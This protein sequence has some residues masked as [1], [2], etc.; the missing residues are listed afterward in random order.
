MLQLY[1]F[2]FDRIGAI[3][4][5][6]STGSWSVTGR[7]LTYSM[8]ELATTTSFPESAFP[9]SAFPTSPFPSALSYFHSL[10]SEQKTHLW[11]QRNLCG[12]PVEAR[13]RYISRHLFAQSVDKYCTNDRGP[14]KFFCDDFRPQNILVDPT[15][16]RITAV[17]D[18]EFSNAMPSQYASEPPW[19]LLLVG[20]DS[21]LLRG[22]TIAG[23]IEAYEPR[24][25]QFLGAMERAEKARD[26]GENG[27]GET[28]LS[29]LMRESWA[30]KR[31]WFNYA[32]RKPFD[33]EVLFDTQLR[34]DGAGIEMLDGEARKGLEPFV[35]MKMAQLKAY[36]NE[37]AKRLLYDYRLVV[38]LNASPS[39][40]HRI[41]Q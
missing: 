37:C 4:N 7:P 26:R 32:A 22:K 20:P 17:L 30:T 12:S 39:D 35:A 28:P 6:P 40:L 10:T 34:G 38:Y 9:E 36:D 23:F 13:Q 33:V 25:E 18:L 15:T 41:K 24:L 8:N 19:W 3:S 11:T 5:V 2:N 16:L 27:D 21:Y 14:F 31:F 1:K 29:S